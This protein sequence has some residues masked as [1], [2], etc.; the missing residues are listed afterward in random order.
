MRLVQ[1]K[2]IGQ[3]FILIYV[4]VLEYGNTL[5]YYSISRMVIYSEI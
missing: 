4:L 5:K 3:R 2:L 1:Y